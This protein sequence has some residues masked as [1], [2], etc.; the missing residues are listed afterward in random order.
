MSDINAGK[1][2]EKRSIN[3]AIA[4]VVAVIAFVLLNILLNLFGIDFLSKCFTTTSVSSHA[5]PVCCHLT[6]DGEH[7]KTLKF[8]F[9]ENASPSHLST[10]VDPKPI[11]RSDMEMALIAW[12]YFEN[13]SQKETGLINSVNNYA[14][15][16][17]WDTG[18]AIAGFIAARELCI[19]SQKEFDDQ[20]SPLLATLKN[21]DLY[22]DIAPN[23]AY[24]TKT[25]KMVDYRNKP[26][27]GGIG[28]S[29]LDLARLVKWLNNLSVA[30]PK[31]TNA[32]RE[33]LKRWDYSYLIHDCQMYGLANDPVTKKMKSLQ[34][35]RLGYE[36]Y[37][38]KIFDDFGFNV[39]ISKNYMNQFSEVA[40]IYDVPILYDKRDPRELGAYNYIVTES[41]VMDIFENGE[42]EVNRKLMDNIYEVQRQRW[43]REG[44]VTAVSEDNI[45][46]RPW[47]IYNTIF[48]VGLPWNTITDRGVIHNNLK[49]TST[50][51]ALTMRALYEDQP[52]SNEL[53]QMVESAYHPE[54]GWYSGVYENGGG[55]NKAI[56]ANTNG[57]ILETVFYK[58]YGTLEGYDCV[59]CRDRSFADEVMGVKP[60]CNQCNSCGS[61]NQETSACSA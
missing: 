46:R 24:N 48:A 25:G 2:N 58:M 41:F 16:T 45:D 55:F 39:D 27:P 57:I 34:E 8:N 17:M 21:M 35:G 54:K 42:D 52:Y 6:V 19:I 32:A 51:A 49:T 15:T 18:S 20:I 56:T 29:T 59:L 28:V 38:G 4:L 47:F 22:N 31:Y 53:Y 43:L 7:C 10:I 26:S 12:K 33:V 5:E 37:A 9:S 1:E 40:I 30:H 60:D 44:I 3:Y 50:K 11:T 14:S 36:Q 23:K 13:N 61:C